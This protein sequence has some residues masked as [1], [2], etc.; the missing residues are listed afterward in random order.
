[1]GSYFVLTSVLQAFIPLRASALGANGTTLGELLLL[2]GGGIGLVTDM[3]FAAY[4][5]ARGRDRVVFGGLTCALLAA[6]LVALN[7]SLVALFAGCFVLGLSNSM[8]FNSLSAL[9]TTTQHHHTQARTQGFNGSVQRFGALLAALMVGLTLASRH[10]ELLAITAIAACLT[11]LL[12]MYGRTSRPWTRRPIAVREGD[13]KVRGLLKQGYRLGISMFRRRKILLAALLSISLNLIFVETNSFVPLLDS[14]HGLR[15]A[16]VITL[17]L[18]ARDLVA[19]AV[20]VVIVLT[21]RDVSSSRLIVGVLI[22]AAIC[23][24]GVG[25][26]TRGTPQTLIL[27]CALQGVAVGV[28]VAATNLL[29]VVGSSDNHRSVAMA[30]SNLMSRVGGVVIPMSLGLTLQLFGLR[31][32]FFAIGGGLAIISL[33]FVGIGFELDRRRPGL[34]FN[35][36]TP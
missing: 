8:V 18:A 3:G 30:A 31:F 16:L 33:M 35:R 19:I 13:V 32:V 10:D 24:V 26:D 9:L 25:L 29:A 27:W 1:M 4:A 20:G 14:H 34:L 11:P 7:G 28:G 21:G 17:A 22:L 5:D 2:T 23:A 36:D 12:V 6:C 15:Q